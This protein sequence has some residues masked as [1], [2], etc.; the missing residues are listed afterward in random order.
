MAGGGGYVG[1]RYC[2]RDLRYGFRQAPT[3]SCWQTKI[4]QLPPANQ[5]RHDLCACIS[6]HVKLNEDGAV[7]RI[8]K[9]VI[10]G[11]SF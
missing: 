6:L 7:A 4:I 10:S 8:Y 3:Y 1:P 11:D 2:S 9:K 5:T